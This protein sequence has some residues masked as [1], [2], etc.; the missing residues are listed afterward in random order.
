MS[1]T[2]LIPYHEVQDEDKLE[3]LVCSMKE[4]GWQGNPLVVHQGHLLNGSH[5]F[6]AAC[7]VKT[8][9]Y[10]FEIPTVNLT[11]EFE[12]PIEA[13]EDL[14]LICEGYGW[15]LEAT[16]MAVKIDAGLAKYYGLDIH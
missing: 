14:E 6:A 4:K 10:L 5:R 13:L 9:N 2:N 1:F 3:R 16:E 12:F 7:I 15:Q 8:D 11:D